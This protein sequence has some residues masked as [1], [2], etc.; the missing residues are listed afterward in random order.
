MDAYGTLKFTRAFEE[1]PPAR[2]RGWVVYYVRT[3]KQLV[4]DAGSKQGVHHSEALEFT[5]GASAG[6]TYA[7]VANMRVDGAAF[8]HH[9]SR[10]GLMAWTIS[11]HCSR[12]PS[13]TGSSH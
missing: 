8:V 11:R 1:P 6:G 5:R 3:K 2:Q 4:Y 9:S 13:L 10:M 7:P 12:E